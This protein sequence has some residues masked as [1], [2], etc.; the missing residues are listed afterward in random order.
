VA[1]AI[2]QPH[3]LSAVL[4][5]GFLLARVLYV[6]CYVKDWSTLRSLVWALG[7]FACLGLM[8]SPLYAGVA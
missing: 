1:E 3:L 4:A 6:V 7:Y 5:I 8:L 2:A